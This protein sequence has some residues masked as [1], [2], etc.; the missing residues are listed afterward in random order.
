MKFYVGQPVICVN[1]DFTRADKYYP[2]ITWPVRGRRYVVRG[3][4]ADGSARIGFSRVVY[5]AIVVMEIRN[6]RVRYMD[7][8]VREAGFWDERFEPATSIED[9]K[10]VATDV[11][12]W[13][14][15][16]DEPDLHPTMPREK[17]DA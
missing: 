16:E 7:G 11:D 13:L 4:V 6:R 9:L 2:G 1:D 17:E 12:L 10:K 14:G 5:A 3:Y 8:G 15:H